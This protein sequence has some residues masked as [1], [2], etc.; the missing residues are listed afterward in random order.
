MPVYNEAAEHGAPSRAQDLPRRVVPFRTLV[1]VVDNASRTTPP[2]CPPSWRDG[3]GEWPH[4][5]CRARSRLR[6]ARA[7]STSPPRSWRTWTRSV[8]I[9]AGTAPPRGAVAVRPRDVAI[10]SRLARGAHVVRGPKRELI[11]RAYNL[12]LS[13][14]CG[15]TSASPVR[16]QGSAP[17]RGRKSLPSSRTTMVLRHRIAGHGGSAWPVNREVPVDWVDDPDSRVKIVSTA[18]NDLRGVWRMLVRRQGPPPH[19]L[20]RGGGG[21]A[22]AIAGVGLIST[23]GYLFLF[24]A[25]RPL[26]GPIGA[27]AVA[28]A[29]ATLFNTAVHREL[30]HTADGQA[31]RARLYAVAG[32]LR[33]GSEF[34][35]LGLLLRSW[36]S[37][38]P[39]PRAGGNHLGTWRRR[40][41][42]C[43]AAR[44]DLRPCAGSGAQPLELSQ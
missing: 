41:P 27:N 28:M 6:A 8:D 23:L 24:V 17:G 4:C 36:W 11:S 42:V 1:T 10:G 44:L 35:T 26:I 3:C 38:R 5:A 7:W 34:T 31:R 18:A 32:A 20:Q 39:A 19:A 37:R 14:R 13:S 22:A 30:S 33:G 2:A 25:W 43:R 15:A 16:L 9:A 29:I 12:L 21:T 40:L